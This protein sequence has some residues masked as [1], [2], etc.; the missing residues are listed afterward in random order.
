MVSHKV[1]VNVERTYI[2][3]ANELKRLLKIKGTV[4]HFEEIFYCGGTGYKITS[5]DEVLKEEIL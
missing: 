2:F 1:K 5:K 4:F 3:T